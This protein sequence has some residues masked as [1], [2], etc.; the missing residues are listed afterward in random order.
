MEHMEEK[1]SVSKTGQT[2]TDGFIS[3]D[4]HNVSLWQTGV[5]QEV[6]D[7]E[8]AAGKIYD[9]LIVGG[10]ITGITAALLLQ[11]A[12]KN[13]VLAEAHNIGFGTTGGTSAHI[14]T[15]ADTTYA[16]TEKS[17]DFESS[18]LFARSIAGAVD[19][20]S[21]NVKQYQIDCDFEWKKGYV[22]SEDDKQ[23]QELD[24][25]YQ[26][27]LK[28]NV[29]AHETDS[30]P[31]HVPFQKAV[32]FD[33]QAQ[34]HPL[35]YIAALQKE[36]VSLGGLFKENTL[37]DAIDSEEGIHT[38]HASNGS[39]KARSVIY[40]THIPPGVNV[41]HFRNAPY[42][43]YV[44]AVTLADQ[45]YPDALVY[46]M[47]DPYHYFRS[48]TIDGQK[49]MIVG[50]HDHKTGHGDEEQAFNDLEEYVRKYYHVKSVDYKWSSQY[51]VPVDGLPYIGQL[52]GAA[53]GI[54]TATGFNGNGMIL[55]TAAAQTLSE[56][57][58]NQNS[59]YKQLYNPARVKPIAA[60]METIKENADV[61]YRFIA[62]RFSVENIESLRELEKNSG[63]VVDYQDKK[64]AV[65]KDPDGKIHALSPV[66][67]HAKCIVEWNNTEISWDCPCHGARYDPDGKVLTGPARKDLEVI[68]LDAPAH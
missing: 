34:F 21:S 45:D 26:S 59:D 3:R 33:D 35:K 66:C 27:A 36:F 44:I 2:K 37:V 16:E 64:L 24:D 5:S 67:T 15:F 46:D 14:N 53:D 58:I 11:K 40:A 51:Y 10:G 39:I 18:Q 25:L 63:T 20:I 13:C 4:G 7:Q 38:A 1:I 62:D 12:G 17:F 47:Q 60:F 41:L 65:Y 9:T 28:V 61:A 23:S 29:K 42:R 31:T 19:L 22:Y 30:V 49:Y 68:N 8:P 48:H 54:Y 6:K 52:P 43:S 50:G 57:I 55:G 32:V 56:L